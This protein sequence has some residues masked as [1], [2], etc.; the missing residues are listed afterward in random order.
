MDNERIRVGII[1]AGGNTRLMHIPGL[2][3]IAGVSID[4]VCNRTRESSEKA[5]GELGIPRVH[6]RWQDLVE[7]PGLDAV[8]IGTWPYMHCPCTIAALRAG[9]H[10]LCEARMAIDAAQ[11]RRMKKAAAA[12]PDLVAQVVPAPY[13]LEMDRTINRLLAEGAVGQVIAADIRGTAGSFVDRESPLHWRQD[14]ALSGRNVLA[15]GI[16]YEMVA[17]WIGHARTVRAMARTVVGTRKQAE[18]GTPVEVTVPDHVDV[19]A[20]MERGAQ[21]RLQVSAVT[22]LPAGIMEAWLFGT[23]ATLRVDIGRKALSILRRGR[24]TM[25]DVPVPASERIGWRVEEEFIGAVRGQEKIERTT[26]DEGVL[27]MEFTD[28]VARAAEGGRTVTLPR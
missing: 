7:D 26:F 2:R 24:E 5:A 16:L 1:G 3:A 8:L 10:V 27:C 21:M 9:K 17:R 22:G 4:A 6:E 20:A 18:S 11:A 13:T 28:A 15:L 12:R 14:A 23:E 25:E 19:L